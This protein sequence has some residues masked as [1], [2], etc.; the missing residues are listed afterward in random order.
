[1]GC[2]VHW[3]IGLGR[4][5]VAISS[6]QHVEEAI[7]RCL[8]DDFSRFVVDLDISK[9]HV[10]GRRVVPSIAGRGLIVPDV[11]TGIRVQGDNRGK[12]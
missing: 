7:F 8:H 12:I 1:M 5:E 3:H 4:D 11:L 2:P 9:D 10:L 6:I